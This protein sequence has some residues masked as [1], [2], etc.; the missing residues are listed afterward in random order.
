MS[1]IVGGF[2]R[3]VGGWLI[4]CNV[5]MWGGIVC[6]SAVIHAMFKVARKYNR[7]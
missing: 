3:D 6:K 7:E 5:G 4:S 2:V 1:Y